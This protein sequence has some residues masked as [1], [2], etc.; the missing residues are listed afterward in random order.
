MVRTD[1]NGAREKSQQKVKKKASS[2][3]VEM[4]RKS[5]LYEGN[6]G[7]GISSPHEETRQTGYQN[8]F[9]GVRSKAGMRPGAK[10]VRPSQ[11][12]GK[13]EG[14]PAIARANRSNRAE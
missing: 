10:R 1:D 13:T 6:Y 9:R 2:P 3:E 8:S 5:E 11:D 14:L 12:I 4:I 7:R